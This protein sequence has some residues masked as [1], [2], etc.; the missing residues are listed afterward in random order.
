MQGVPA[1]AGCAAPPA[2]GDAGRGPAGGRPGTPRPG[3]MVR[4]VQR[5]YPPGA[6]PGQVRGRPAPRGSARAGR[7]AAV[8][9]R[10]CR[11]GSPGPGA[12]VAGPCPRPRLR[13][14]S[15]DR[16]GSGRAGAGLPVSL[17]LERTR[18]TAAQFD[19]NCG[20]SRNVRGAFRLSGPVSRTREGTRAYRDL[21]GRLDRAGRRRPHD[22]QHPRRVR[23]GAHGSW[24]A[25]GLGHHRGAGT[26]TCR[27]RAVRQVRAAG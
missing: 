17:L 5:R 13:P 9:A 18:V 15:A 6:P 7:G 14:G 3:G 1:G 23:H 26:L 16:P 8:G 2:A 19:L 4:A 27:F 11:R 24:R 20:R 25:R 21:G 10:R 22:G 12:G